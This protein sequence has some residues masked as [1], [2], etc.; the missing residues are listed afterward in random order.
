[1]TGGLADLFDVVR[2]DAL[3]QVGDPRMRRRHDAREVRD[4]GHHARD[5]EH[6]GGIVADERGG[7]D[8]D[9]V[10]LLEEVEIALRDFRRIHRGARVSL[11]GGEKFRAVARGV[12]GLP[13]R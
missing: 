5:R 4:E 8:D 10:V 11:F 6:Q 2:A 12:S 9:V 3:L 1:M 7:G 13:A